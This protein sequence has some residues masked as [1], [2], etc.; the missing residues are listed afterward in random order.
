LIDIGTHFSSF[1]DVAGRTPH[2]LKPFQGEAAVR[3][4][5]QILG[6]GTSGISAGNGASGH[7]FS[8]PVICE[9]IR[10]AGAFVREG[11]RRARIRE[12]SKPHRQGRAKKAPNVDTTAPPDEDFELDVIDDRTL[13][14]YNSFDKHDLGVTVFT[15][16]F[17]A[18][19]FCPVLMRSYIAMDAVE[20]LDV[21]RE[22]QF[23]KFVVKNEIANLLLRLWCHPNGAS[24]KFLLESADDVLL[25][26][27]FSSVATALG[28]QMDY[29]CQFIIDTRDIRIAHEQQF[30]H[31][32]QSSLPPLPAREEFTISQHARRISSGMASCRLLLTILCLFSRE[33]AIAALLGGA[34]MA[35]GSKSAVVD[36]AAVV[37]TVIERLTDEDGGINNDLELEHLSSDDRSIQILERIDNVPPHVLKKKLRYLLQS[38]RFALVD[39]GLDVSMTM[40]QLFALASRWHLAAASTGRDGMAGSFLVTALA[41]ND[42]FSL[43]QFRNVFAR[44]TGPSKEM[45][46]SEVDNADYILHRDGHV[47]ITIWK[48]SYVVVGSGPDKGR[49]QRRT[50]KQNR[51]TY[52]EV[53]ALASNED[54]ELLLQDLERAVA[55]K[56]VFAVAARWGQAAM[57]DMERNL[58]SMG[59]NIGDDDYSNLMKEWVVSSESFLSESGNGSFVHSFDSIVRCRGAEA[60]GASKLLLGEARKCQKRLAAPHPNTSVFVCFAE[61]RADLCKAIIIGSAGTPFAMGVYEFDILFPPSYPA[62]PPL[63]N[64]KTTGAWSWRLS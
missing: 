1:S 48:E 50:A 55:C 35:R 25:N 16:D 43:K 52:S 49:T 17:V 58:L 63:F 64:F 51:M 60:I 41:K 23:D 10:I 40:H 37:I 54:M 22:N 34:R 21:E 12:K 46:G 62:S 28:F 33:D 11:V 13:D 14:I 59:A 32:S 44:L 19:H 36:L 42:S 29:A 6:E 38:R 2:L 7:S 47:D 5:I 20:G 18:E 56:S 27:F 4:A 30:S 57:R 45:T 15:N 53:E 24:K 39:Y 61:E 26:E 8:P 3:Y 31:L 9:L